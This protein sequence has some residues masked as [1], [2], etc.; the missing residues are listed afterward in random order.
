MPAILPAWISQLGLDIV[1]Q[2]GMPGIREASL[3]YTDEIIA[4]A[5]EAGLPVLTPRQRSRRAGVVALRFPG[6]EQ[7]AQQMQREGYV[8]SCR[9]ALRIAPHFYNT[10]DE[11][12][13]FMDA[14]VKSARLIEQK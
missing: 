10:P 1:S 6:Q 14:L 2:V 4:R 12:G 9:G 13:R 5:D 11:V 7:V 8:C 3:R